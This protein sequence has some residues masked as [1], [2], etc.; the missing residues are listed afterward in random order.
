MKNLVFASDRDNGYANIAL[1]GISEALR[2]NDVERA[3]REARDLAARIR[4]AAATVVAAT[5]A[6]LQPR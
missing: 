5:S 2:D 6:V 4:A 1:P 3:R